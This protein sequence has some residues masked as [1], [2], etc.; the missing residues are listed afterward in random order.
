MGRTVFAVR[1]K[2][3]EYP[4]FEEAVG[5][6]IEHAGV[7]PEWAAIAVAGPVENDRAQFTNVDW[8]V[9]ADSLRSHFAFSEVHLLNDFEAL[10]HYAATP[11][12]SGLFVLR[13]GHPS[14]GAPR[15]VMGPGSGLGQSIAIPR[16]GPFA[17]SVIA[18]EGGHTF[19]PIATDDEDRLRGRLHAALGHAPTTENVLSG[20]GLMRLTSAMLGENAAAYPS[21]AALTGAALNG[22]EAARR[23][24]T[25]FFNFLGSAVRNALYATGARGG[26]F[27][28]GGIVPRLIPLI[29]ESQFLSRVTENDPCGAYL[30][31]IPITVIVAEGAALDGA[32]R[33]LAAHR[34]LSGANG[35]ALGFA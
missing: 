19:L 2:A 6:A 21:A 20:S 32:W 7:R 3:R 5:T 18:A 13:R 4:T 11:D 26:V 12:P 27:L 16:A 31:N 22:D 1:L 15:L 29:A 8:S 23:V 34:S 14:S 9:S 33:A 28:A 25:Q 35:A 17:P 30:A 24:T 10:G